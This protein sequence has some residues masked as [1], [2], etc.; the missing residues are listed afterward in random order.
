MSKKALLS[1][2]VLLL[3]V[4]SFAENY[5]NR[6]NNILD[7][8]TISSKVLGRGGLGIVMKGVH[9]ETGRIVAIKKVSFTPEN[10]LR[11]S[12]EGLFLRY[13]KNMGG[14]KNIITL[15]DSFIDE[16]KKQIYLVFDL[17]DEGE[18][19]NLLDSTV[20]FSYDEVIEWTKQLV[21]ALGYLEKL[22]IAHRDIKLENIMIR[23]IDGKKELVIID[24]GMAKF[25]NFTPYLHNSCC[26]TINY[27]SPDCLNNDGEEDLTKRDPFALGVVL[28]T[29]L[30]GGNL[31]WKVS[32]NSQYSIQN[33]IIGHD[34]DLLPDIVGQERYNILVRYVHSLLSPFSNKRK[35][36]DEKLGFIKGQVAI[37][38]L[39]TKTL[40]S[41]ALR[42][43][44]NY[45]RR[46]QIGF[47][48]D[49]II[50]CI[51]EGKDEY[52]SRFYQ[53][54]CMQYP[55]SDVL[56]VEELEQRAGKVNKPLLNIVNEIIC[57]NEKY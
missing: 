55:F 32:S 17:L 4:Q 28:Y 34:M 50:D 26:G 24:F 37:P 7:E 46:D 40:N 45:H 41:D 3:C 19:F 31:P 42:F 13:I 43:I 57:P 56:Q 54:L 23:T 9:N 10:Y 22:G 51:V 35:L 11:V 6:T 2:L 8:Y 5:F 12:R 16:K 21:S 48:V 15:I 39:G 49:K 47:H 1:L 27:V 38:L 36:E 52:I 25:F 30:S 44:L 20:I 18:L 53:F 29:L 33:A 14:H